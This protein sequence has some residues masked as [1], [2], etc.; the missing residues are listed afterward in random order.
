MEIIYELSIKQ[1]SQIHS[2]YQR[3]WWTNQRTLEDT[4]SCING[5]QICIAIID[6]DE[7]VIGFSRVLTDYI[8]KA[9]IFDVIVDSNF[10]EKGIGNRLIHAIKSHP[11]LKNV[12]AFEL[13]CLP[14]VE[15]F[16]SRHGFSTD[17]G[18]IS[19]MRLSHA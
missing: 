12:K 15:P 2:L 10:R 5:S 4:A 13:Y 9:L 1:I 8:F 7:N 14:E 6:D 16:Y 3:E 19:L 17:L 18:G 11:Q